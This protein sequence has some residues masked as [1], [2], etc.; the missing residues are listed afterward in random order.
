[1]D[2]VYNALQIVGLALQ[3]VLVVLVSRFLRKYYLL[4]I[5]SAALL[6]TGALEAYVMHRFGVQSSIYGTLYWS[7]EVVLDFLRFSIVISL[8]YQA[9]AG[10][11]VAPA[12]RKLLLGILMAATLL[13]FV[14][15]NGPLFTIR[16]FNGTSQLLN[17]GG[18]IM[19][20]AL[21]TVLLA[22][23]S[24]DPRLLLVSVGVGISV[25]GA[26]IAWGVRGLIQ[27]KYW[28]A[29]NLF[30]ILTDLAGVLVWCWAFRPG[31]ITANQREAGD[32]A[33]SS[34]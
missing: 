33:P 22:S 4:L 7:N 12:I 9:S 26:A 32:R 13:P 17:F 24:R 6:V 31:T 5:Y 20:L 2:E 25:T 11:P 29:P 30:L 34:V 1:M 14:L 19:N 16:W 10:S 18:A 27:A 28:W 21:W 23:K 3:A 8:A 15:L